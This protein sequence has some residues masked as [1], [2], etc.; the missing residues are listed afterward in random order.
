MLYIG[1]QSNEEV[2]DIYGRNTESMLHMRRLATEN[3]EC[4]VAP[5][6]KL[7]ILTHYQA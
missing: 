7:A 4:S 1:P 3:E 5:Q 6:A 2:H